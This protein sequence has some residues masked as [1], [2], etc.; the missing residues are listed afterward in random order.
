VGKYTTN[1]IQYFLTWCV[2]LCT[3]CIL[4]CLVNMAVNFPGCICSCLLGIVANLLVLVVLCVYCF[5][6][7]CTMCE[8]LYVCVAGF[9]LDDELLARSQYSEGPVTGYLDTGFSWFPCGYKQMLRW[10]PRFQ[11]ATTCFSCSPPDLNLN[12]SL[13]SFIFLFTCEITTA[14]RGHPNCS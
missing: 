5:H 11:V 10:L 12:F 7:C 14:T 4:N 9:T 2:A 3:C 1:Y 6:I 13:T 8:L